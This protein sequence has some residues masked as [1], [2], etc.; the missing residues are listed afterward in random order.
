MKQ[1]TGKAKVVAE[2]YKSRVEFKTRKTTISVDES[3]KHVSLHYTFISI[4]FC[5][6][7]FINLHD[8]YIYISL[9]QHMTNSSCP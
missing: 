6:T 9:I 1:L 4:P 7:L 2:K 3:M 8:K 5:Q